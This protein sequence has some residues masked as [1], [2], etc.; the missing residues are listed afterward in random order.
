MTDHKHAVRGE[1]RENNGRG[2]SLI[3]GTGGTGDGNDDIGVGIDDT[4]CRLMR[5]IVGLRASVSCRTAV[6]VF[7][8]A[9]YV[10]R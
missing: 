7:S 3:N 6:G 1:Q 2:D 9:R 10:G 8:G 4:L 5:S